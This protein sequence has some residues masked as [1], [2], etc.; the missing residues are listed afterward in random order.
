VT[1]TS[2]ASA[3][4][5]ALAGFLAEASQAPQ[6]VLHLG[7]VSFYNP[8]LMFLKHQPMVDY[9]TATTG[10]RW[11]L[12]VVPSYERL[13]ED[14][15]SRKM[16]A[17]YIGPFAY[18]RARAACKAIPLAT[19]ASAGKP[20]YRSLVMVRDDSPLKTLAD[21]A[22]KTVG[23]GPPMATAAHLVAR[24]MLR[25]AG[26][27]PGIDV[28][29]RHYA[30]QEEPARAVLRGEV[31]ACGIREFVGEQFTRRGLRVLAR[32]EEIPGFLLALAPGSEPAL[33]DELVRVL[34]SLPG[35]DSGAA[36]AIR[37]WDA[38]LAGGFVR[39]SD[40]AYEP[41]RRMAVRLFGPAALT[42]PAAS[43]E[44]R[45]PEHEP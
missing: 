16:T 42:I 6:P 5:L 25:D 7:V 21:L 1:G 3:L 12:V 37:A 27:N 26:L 30:H 36:K 34:V 19:L 10:R 13:V 17:A 31:D 9:L 43:L 44:C 4:I 35:Q 8:R 28:G 39:A 45:S 18:A 33:R 24:S 23:F 22:G 14:L 40:A 2:A 11:D 29:C 38:E 41:V 20:T 15:C 32:S